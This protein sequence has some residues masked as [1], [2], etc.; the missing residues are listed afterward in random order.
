M[1]DADGKDDDEPPDA[2]LERKKGKGRK[3]KGKTSASVQV[4]D[5]ANG[6]KSGCLWWVTALFGFAFTG[7]WE[8][9][10]RREALTI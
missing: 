6:R 2:A 9:E 5:K 3:S 10:A 8:V 4:V 7:S 1:K